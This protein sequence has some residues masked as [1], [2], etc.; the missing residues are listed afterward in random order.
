[1]EILG[2]APNVVLEDEIG[3]EMVEVVAILIVCVRVFLPI[4][5]LVLH[6]VAQAD[7]RDAALLHLRSQ[8]TA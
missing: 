5:R 7:V 1:M 8:S 4:E 2:R 3:V 6:V